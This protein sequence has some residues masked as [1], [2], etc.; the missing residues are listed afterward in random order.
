[1]SKP[2]QLKHGDKVVCLHYKTHPIC[3][4]ECVVKANRSNSGEEEVH[5]TEIKGTAGGACNWWGPRSWFRKV[6]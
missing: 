2:I 4:V 3:R 1:M 5:I 6:A